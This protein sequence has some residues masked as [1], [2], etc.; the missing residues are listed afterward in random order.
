MYNIFL[1]QIACVSPVEINKWEKYL[2]FIEEHKYF[3]YFT[4]Y[5]LY[6]F[7]V[8]DLKKG[9]EGGIFLQ[10]FQIVYNPYD[11]LNWW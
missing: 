7:T 2:L 6:I 4:L 3:M 10:V 9:W 5:R 1:T 11:G 8:I